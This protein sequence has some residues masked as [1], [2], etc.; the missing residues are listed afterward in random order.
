MPVQRVKGGY[1]YGNSGKLYKGKD[2]K[3][4]AIK[5]AVAIQYA[6]KRAGKKQEGI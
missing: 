2:A 3:E 1:R 6:E 5:Q 4:K